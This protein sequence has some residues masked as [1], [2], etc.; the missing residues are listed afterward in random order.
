MASACHFI[1]FLASRASGDRWVAEHPGTVLL[2]LDEAFA[3]GRLQN[4][5]LFGKELARRSR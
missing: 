2:S 1:F 5:H 3:A 4:L